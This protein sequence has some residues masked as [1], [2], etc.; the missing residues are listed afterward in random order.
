MCARVCGVRSLITR[1]AARPP[2]HA[3]HTRTHPPYPQPQRHHHQPRRHA[4]T[5]PRTHDCCR[6]TAALPHRP[7]FRPPASGPVTAAPTAGAPA[8]HAPATA[9]EQPPGQRASS[10]GRLGTPWG[11]SEAGVRRRRVA[12]TRCPARRGRAGRRWRTRCRSHSSCRRGCVCA[13]CDAAAGGEHS[14]C[15]GIGTG[16]G[17]GTAHGGV[18]TDVRPSVCCVH[19][20]PRNSCRL[21]HGREAH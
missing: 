4:H 7:A 9:A 15:T 20:P 1:Q 18:S 21:S 17:T 12:V 14:A 5:P 19:A 8:T 2:P 13:G 16:T 6:Q 10:P 3:P 11:R